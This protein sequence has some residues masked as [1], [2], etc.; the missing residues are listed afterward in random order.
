MEPALLK[1]ARQNVPGLFKNMDLLFAFSLFGIVALLILPVSASLIDL[2]LALSIGISL[3]ILLVVIYVKDPPEF[4]VFPTILLAVTL[5]RLGLNIASTRLILLDG[6]AGDIIDSF[7]HFVVRDNYVVG[8]VIFC[9]LVI[10]NFVVITKGAGRIAEVAARFTLDAMP[11]KQMSIDAELN[12]GLI[13]EA[14]ASRRRIKIQKEA[15]FYGS[16]DGAS[17]FV[18]GDAIAGILITLIN[19]IGGIAIG[20]S[21]KGMPLVEALHRYT[22]LSIGDGLVSQIPALIVSVG[23]GILVTRTSEG[24]NLGEYIGRQLTFYPRAICIL[25]TMLILFAIAPGMPMLPFLSLGLVCLGGAYYMKKKG[26][27]ACDESSE[28]TDGIGGSHGKVDVSEK[29]AEKKIGEAM[30]MPELDKVIRVDIF[31]IEIGFGLLPL[32]DTRQN[33]DL[34]DRITG[35]RKSLAREI[36]IIIP[37]V[38]IRDNPEL[39]STQYR[40]LLRNKEIAKG[41]VIPSR[42]MAMNVAQSKA[43]LKG[44]ATK[45]PVF[46]LEAVWIADDEKSTAEMN[47]YTV[48]DATSVLITH[49]SEILKENA[50]HILERQHVQQLIEIVK[51]RNETLVNELLPDL[52]SVGLIQRVLQNLLRERISIKNLTL[53]LETISDFATF[54]KNPD[55]LSEQ[56][57]KRLGIYFVQDYETDPGILKAITLEPRLEQILVARVKKTQYDAILMMDPTLAQFFIKTLAGL[58]DEM[59]GQGLTPIMVV[60]SDLRLAFKR[61]FEPS[62]PKLQLLAYQE[63][64]N[65]IQIENFALITMPSDANVPYEMAKKN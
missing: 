33:G 22:L 56:V 34:L 44:I 39:E 3:L 18:R 57:R 48:V 37:A 21:Q 27:G 58:L 13:D 30:A 23:A 7:G 51:E 28:Q 49:L 20:V 2:L 15:D 31:A 60:T 1:D 26:L 10:I 32:A 63:I 4:S 43:V 54:T 59:L 5:Y 52:V 19:I 36:G 47:G 55:E 9:I 42:W 65:Q 16:M 12:A 35:V 46:G 40:F 25:G 29:S 61:F 41:S 24:A 6:Y 45:E 38:S 64:P 53:I 8:G 14:T 50:H 62:F 11:G 17:K